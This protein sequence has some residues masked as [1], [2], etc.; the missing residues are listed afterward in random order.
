MILSPGSNRE[1]NPGV[2]IITCVKNIVVWLP[3]NSHHHNPNRSV[4][5]LDGPVRIQ[6][7]FN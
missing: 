2:I 7:I 5:A 4:K 3:P 1:G 6:V